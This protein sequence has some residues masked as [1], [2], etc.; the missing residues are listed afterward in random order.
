MQRPEANKEK[1]VN[2]D[3]FI[4]AWN[5]ISQALTLMFRVAEGFAIAVA[6]DLPVDV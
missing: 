6:C 2:I 5:P 4:Q 3:D 1:R